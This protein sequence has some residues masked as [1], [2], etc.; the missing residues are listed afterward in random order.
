VS[1]DAPRVAIYSSIMGGYEA[2]AKP[3]PHDLPCPAY[4]FTDRTDLAR[5]CR[6]AGWRPIV[7]NGPY[8]HFE[9]DPANGDPAVV[10]PML[11][12][13]YW[14]THP[15]EAMET[16]EQHNVDVSV[17]MDGSMQVGGRLPGQEFVDRCLGALGDDD[18]SLMRHPWRSCIY[19]EAVYSSTLI[20]RYDSAAM[21]RQHDHYRDGWAHPSHWGLFA[22]GMMVRRHTKAVTELGEAWWWHNLKWSHQD[23]I[24]L[25]VLIRTA[26]GARDDFRW[27]ANLPWLLDG[28]V[29]LHPH[30]A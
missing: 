16:A 13:K 17:W 27:N 4:M 11:A 21:M 18:W 1:A 26:S 9:P 2:T 22:T 8:G 30:G 7:S 25:P 5:Q 6:S 28:G 19:D 24:S 20:Y 12:H 14:K 29:E 3:L 15:V 10:R 23:Q